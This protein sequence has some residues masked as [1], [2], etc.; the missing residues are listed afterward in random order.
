MASCK[1]NWKNIQKLEKITK[2]MKSFLLKIF[3]E[4]IFQNSIYSVQ[5]YSGMISS[6]TWIELII[7]KWCLIRK[8]ISVTDALFSLK[9]IFGFEPFASRHLFVFCSA[10][11]LKLSSF[12][13]VSACPWED[14]LYYIVFLGFLYH[15]LSNETSLFNN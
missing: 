6:T 9:F 3:Q 1:V 5:Q 11:Y 2:K 8:P 7:K 4:G 14:S 12:Y 15:G 13:H 10:S